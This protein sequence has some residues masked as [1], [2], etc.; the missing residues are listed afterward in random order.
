VSTS[1]RRSPRTRTLK[2]ALYGARHSAH[3]E[4]CALRGRRSARASARASD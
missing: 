4:R 3:A 2:R 1:G